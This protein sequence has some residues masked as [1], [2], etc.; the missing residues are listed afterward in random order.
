MSIIVQKYG[1]SSV[2]DVEKIKNVARRVAKSR[3][4]GNQVVVVVSAMG[5]TTDELV[6]LANKVTAHP[7]GR[8]YDLLLST[9]EL[10]SCTL[11]AMALNTIGYRA[12]SLSGAQAGIKTDT[13]Y[14]RAHILGINP[15]RIT[16]ELNDGN[17]VVVAGF[18]GI[19][20]DKDV[21]TLEGAVPIP[22]LWLWQ[23]A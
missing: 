12:V 1:G 5:D 20:K 13:E 7:S 8:E 3:D 14:N 22:L 9:G 16:E 10:V 6:A 4:E 2:A 15:K 11:L 21:T 17:V 23:S 19:N 18:Q